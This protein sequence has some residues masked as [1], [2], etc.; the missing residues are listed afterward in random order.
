[1]VKICIDAGHFGKVNRSPAIKEY[2][3]SDMNWKL[4]LLLKK[5]LE[6]YGMETIT[7]RSDQDKDLDLTTR[8]RA[9]KGCDL[10][11]SLHSNASGSGIDEKNDYPLACCQ[12]DGKADKLGKALA[13]TV[14][15]IMGTKQLGRIYKRKGNNGDY[16]GVLRGAAQVGTMGIILEHS[17]HTQ[18]NATRW[19]LDDAN[20]AKLAKAE[21]ECIANYFGVQ[22]TTSDPKPYTLELPQLY[23]GCKGDLV[24]SLQALL[25]AK[26]YSCG[27]SGVDGS[28]GP[29]TDTAVRAFQQD[30]GLKADGFVGHDTMSALMGL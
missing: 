27:A 1:M 14:A 2:Y 23:K 6:A 17:F 28:F 21:A 10:F 4:H 15:R 9:A 20:L 29:A 5:E 16:Y 11:L 19:L 30:C 25:I 24:R 12:I 22:K 3:E 18:T 26:G 7:T 13:D 8:G